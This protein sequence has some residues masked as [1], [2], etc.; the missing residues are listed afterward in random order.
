MHRSRVLPVDDAEAL[1]REHVQAVLSYAQKLVGNRGLA[2]DLAADAFVALLQNR[3]RRDPALVLGWLKRV[4]RNRAIDLWRRRATEDKYAH[5]LVGVP[6]VPDEPLDDWL[7]KCTELRPLHRTCLL[8]KL[9][10]GRTVPE[11]A[12]ATG[13]TPVRVKGYLQY[14]L[15]LLRLTYKASTTQA[16]T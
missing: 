1:Y 6:P 10:E 13:L 15:K 2:E 7:Q 3:E 14:G 16:E 11:I 8:L 12:S 9:V 5:L 4:V